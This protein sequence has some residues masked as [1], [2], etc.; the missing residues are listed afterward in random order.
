[1]ALVDVHCHL[2]HPLIKDIKAVLKRAEESGVKEIITSGFDK[3]TNRKALELGKKFGVKVSLGLYP[4]DTLQKEYAETGQNFSDYDVD[5]EIEF[6]RKNKNSISAVGE[7]GLDF[8]G[9]NPDKNEQ[10][11]NFAKAI[12]L[13]KELKKPLIVHSRKAEKEVL[14][15]LEEEKAEKVIMHCFCGGKNRV[16]EAAKKGYYF[17]IPANVNRS[18][19]FQMIVKEVNINQLLTETDTPYMSPVKGELSE[20]KDVKT[21]VQKIAEIKGFTKEETE[22][23]IFL[24][25]INVFR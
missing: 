10:G 13:S 6:I 14:A 7:A 9:E 18:D 16:K 4:K 11:K 3:A 25:F 22:N 21:A 15:I 1:M 2:D 20:P 8:S 24:N 12:A 19:N 5:E 23:N 17:S